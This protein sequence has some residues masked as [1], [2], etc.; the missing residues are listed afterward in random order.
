MSK[1]LKA[2]KCPSDQ[3]S[4]TNCAIV[5]PREFEKVRHVEICG[6]SEKYIFSVRADSLVS[7][8]EIGFSAVQVPYIKNKI[9]VLK[10]FHI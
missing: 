4:L 10:V 6:Q 2:I 5:N 3:L 8:G 7:M 1:Q 9:H